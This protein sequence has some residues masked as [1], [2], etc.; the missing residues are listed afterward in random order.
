MQVAD[1]EVTT[2]DG[3]RWVVDHAQ[4]ALPDNLSPDEEMRA[5]VE[6]LMTE[7][8]G[9]TRVPNQLLGSW[10]H[11]VRSEIGACCSLDGPCVEHK[12]ALAAARLVLGRGSK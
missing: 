6:K 3:R 10:L 12:A 2:A 7:P 8:D 1:V 11:V 9:E 5:A 4:L